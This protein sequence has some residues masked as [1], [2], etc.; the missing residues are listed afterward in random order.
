MNPRKILSIILMAL[1]LGMPAA[2]IAAVQTGDAAPDIQFTDTHGKQHKISDFK[3]KKVVLEWNN[4]ECPFVKKFYNAKEMQRLQAEATKAGI[5]WVTINSS[6]DGKQGFFAD[7]EAA[8]AYIKQEGLAS[9]AYVRDTEGKLGKAFGAK[10]TPHMY[11]IDAEGKLAY[12]G[13]IDSIKSASSADINKAQ[14]YVLA[15]LASLKSGEKVTQGSTEAY[16]CAV[17]Y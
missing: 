16:G 7:D 5:V 4:P 9:T 17:K 2:A 1:M 3:G 15:S 11:V 10:V 12:Q 6:A 13:A 14:N 8:N